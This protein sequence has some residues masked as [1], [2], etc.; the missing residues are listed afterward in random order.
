MSHPIERRHTT[1]RMSKSVCH[2]GVAYLCGQTSNGS[3]ATDVTNQNR[4][5][6]SRVDALLAELGSSRLRLLAAVIYLKSIDD[7]AA[8]N[9]VWEEW[10]P[11]GSAPARTTVE[12]RLA[13]NSLL[14]EITVTAAT[15]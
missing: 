4:E 1:A 2:N 8:M 9:A 12:A 11:E 5:V 10:I 13:S 6:L 3:P 15:H 14:V 7:F